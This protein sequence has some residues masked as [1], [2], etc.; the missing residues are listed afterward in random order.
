M[1]GDREQFDRS[2][3]DGVEMKKWIK[4]AL[5]V[6]KG[7]CGFCMIRGC[8]HR[9]E[10]TYINTAYKYPWLNVCHRHGD[11]LNARYE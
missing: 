4:R 3:D 10:E 8:W 6:L 7:S 1:A 11:A 9:S 2:I 5:K